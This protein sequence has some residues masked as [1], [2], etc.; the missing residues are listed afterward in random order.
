VNRSE[1]TFLEEVA[2]EA[3]GRETES[4]IG[5][6]IKV[7]W[8]STDVNDGDSGIVAVEVETGSGKVRLD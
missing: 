7:E 4:A 2:V 3:F 5:S 1:E 6:G 8:V